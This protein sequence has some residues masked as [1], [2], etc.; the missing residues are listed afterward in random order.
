MAWVDV[1]CRNF[2]WECW[3]TLKETTTNGSHQFQPH[4]N[5][6]PTTNLYSLLALGKD[7][8]KDLSA[9]YNFYVNDL[10]SNAKGPAA[11]DGVRGFCQNSFPT[12]PN[13]ELWNGYR[14]WI[15]A[16]VARLPIL[17]IMHANTQ[18][19]RYT[20]DTMS[21]QTAGKAFIHTSIEVNWHRV[22]IIAASIMVGQILVILVVFY[23]CN[24]VY[25]R[26]DSYLATAE[27]L[28]T[29]ITRFDGGKL[30]TG[31][32]LAVSLGGV[33]GGPVSYG[34]REGQDGG[35]PEVDLARGL[36]ANF[37]PFPQKRRF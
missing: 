30:M 1:A 25:P 33:L 13:K 22:A 3:P 36:N 27:L 20:R 12:P 14:F 37:P 34:T 9:D 31:E 7:A 23:Y 5:I 11:L 35:P 2:T 6:F 17:A 15:S 19:S 8:Q 32:E 4:E 24:G 16:E 21:N 18:L 26:D 28:K 29:V 10:F